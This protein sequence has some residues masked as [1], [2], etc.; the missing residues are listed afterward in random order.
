MDFI[1]E[2][3]DGQ[4]YLPNF[5]STNSLVTEHKWSYCRFFNPLWPGYL[6]QNHKNMS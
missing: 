4:N 5:Q 1:A 6:L 2:I 3:L